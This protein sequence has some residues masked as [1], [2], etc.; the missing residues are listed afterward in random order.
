MK[1]FYKCVDCNKYI[2]SKEIIEMRSIKENVDYKKYKCLDCYNK[3]NKKS[4]SEIIFKRKKEG[5]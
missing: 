4:I 2:E 3:Y 5:K 1:K